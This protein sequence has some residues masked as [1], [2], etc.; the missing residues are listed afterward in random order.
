MGEGVVP[1]GGFTLVGGRVVG[2][3][4]AGEALEVAGAPLEVAGEAL[5]V[6]GAPLEVAG[7]AGEGL[8]VAGEALLV[9]GEVVV[10]PTHVRRAQGS[11]QFPG[12]PCRL[13]FLHFLQ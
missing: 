11:P 13:M 4:M 2:A 7:V 3:G 5:G 1:A 10:L 12:P 6:A 8:E 9:A